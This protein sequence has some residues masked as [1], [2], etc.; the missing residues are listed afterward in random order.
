MRKP[1]I[2]TPE[3]EYDLEA[4]IPSS[5]IEAMS[6]VGWNALYIYEHGCRVRRKFRRNKIAATHNEKIYKDKQV[7]V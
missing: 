2:Y 4:P 7:R 1:V 6:R 5:I 3:F